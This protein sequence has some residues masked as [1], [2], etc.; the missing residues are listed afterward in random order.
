MEIL[1]TQSKTFQVSSLEGIQELLSSLRIES[2][3]A[4]NVG[5][6][7]VIN[8]TAPNNK[9]HIIMK[10]WDPNTPALDQMVAMLLLAREDNHG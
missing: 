8:A 5:S 1:V 10:G 6:N 7:L 9:I 3:Q 2:L 4:K